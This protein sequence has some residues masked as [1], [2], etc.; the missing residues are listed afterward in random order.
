MN[1]DQEIIKILEPFYREILEQPDLKLSRNL[2]ADDVETWDSLNHILL[3]VKCEEVLDIK[4]KAEELSDLL[5]FGEFLDL[6]KRNRE[7]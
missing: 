2:S 7:S 4:F 6:I 1:E 3:I 5:N